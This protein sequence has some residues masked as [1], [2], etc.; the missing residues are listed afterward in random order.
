MYYSYIFSVRFRHAIGRAAFCR[1]II[2]KFPFYNEYNIHPL[3]E[4]YFRIVGLVYANKRFH[5]QPFDSFFRR[6]CVNDIIESVYVAAF[7]KDVC[8]SFI[9]V[10]RRVRYSIATVKQDFGHRLEDLGYVRAFFV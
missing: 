6:S 3:S 1:A 7:G 2:F 10:Q 8:I 4:S 9:R 5:K